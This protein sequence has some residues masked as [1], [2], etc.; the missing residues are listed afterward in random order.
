MPQ[1]RR[2]EDEPVL[3]PP[4]GTLDLRIRKRIRTKDMVQKEALRLFDEKGYDQTTVDDIAHAAA[5]SPRTFFRYFPTKEDV[6]LWD[7]Y[8]EYP[9]ENVLRLRSDEDVLTQL[10]LRVRELFARVYR[11]DPDRVLARTR[12]SFTVPEVRARFLD[13]QLMMLGPYIA[14]IEELVGV[15]QDDMTIR[16]SLV[17]IFGAIFVALERWQRNGG[18]DDLLQLVDEAF[19]T[20]VGTADRLRD[21]ARA[22]EGSGAPSGARETP[23]AASRSSSRLT[24]G[25]RPAR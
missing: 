9:M 22:A 19:G 8:D 10:T 23:A 7:E 1:H 25:R 11:D 13:Q 16:V 2:S 15:H 17:A 14:R 5:M 3:D 6:V 24:E 20:L 18:R 4:D 12:L 21:T